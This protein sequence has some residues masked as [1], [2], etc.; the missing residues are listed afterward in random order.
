MLKSGKLATVC[1]HVGPENFQIWP[2]VS[3][4]NITITFFQAYIAI[5]QTLFTVSRYISARIFVTSGFKQ[6]ED[7]FNTHLSLT[8]L[9]STLYYCADLSSFV[10]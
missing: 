10:Y 9:S 4:V 7:S 3:N 6:S 8:Y 5:Y 1:L 2:Q